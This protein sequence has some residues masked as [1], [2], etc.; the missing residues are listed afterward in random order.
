MIKIANKCTICSKKGHDCLYCPNKQL[1]IE[2]QRQITTLPKNKK[3][4]SRKRKKKRSVSSLC[5][6]SSDEEKQKS[7][8]V[9]SS[10]EEEYLK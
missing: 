2:K 3:I 9:D 1:L 8:Q 10:S 6:S 5:E 7:T 4:T